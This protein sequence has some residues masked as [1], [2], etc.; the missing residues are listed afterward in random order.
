MEPQFVE[1][2]TTTVQRVL[3]VSQHRVDFSQVCGEVRV[4]VRVRVEVCVEVRVR[5]KD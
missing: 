2:R 3:S 1:V 5:M 4:S